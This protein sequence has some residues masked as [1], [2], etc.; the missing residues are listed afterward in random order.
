[1][2]VEPDRLFDDGAPSTPQEGKVYFGL[3]AAHVPEGQS[4][5]AAR[6]DDGEYTA[7]FAGA[8]VYDGGCP[9]VKLA[10]PGSDQK[11]G[12]S[13]MCGARGEP[14]DDLHAEGF[15][16][17]AEVIGEEVSGSTREIVLRLADQNAVANRPILKAIRPDTR[18]CPMPFRQPLPV[19]DRPHRAIIAFIESNYRR[20]VAPRRDCHSVV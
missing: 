6:L 18:P 4:P 15:G 19:S 2:I 17:I 20:P 3:R 8:V 16:F 7:S 12:E 1:M 13:G 10:L 11:P 5:L 14:E 9:I